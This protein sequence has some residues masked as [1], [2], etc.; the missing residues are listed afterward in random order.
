MKKLIVAAFA[1]AFAA[2]A[3]AATVTWDYTST[4]LRIG[5]QTNTRI[6]DGTLAYLVTTDFTQSAAVEAFANSNGS[7]E[8][9]LSAAS[10]AGALFSGIASSTSGKFNPT[11]VTGTSADVEAYFIVFNGENMFVSSA[12]QAVVNPLDQ[13]SSTIAFTD[14]SAV[15]KAL[16]VNAGEGF[17]SAGWYAAPEPTSG[18]LMLIGMGALALRRRRA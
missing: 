4:Y 15:S 14:G 7:S 5:D 8:A 1:V 11:G 6:A 2:A 13:T 3:Q 10:Q 9:V 12:E 16:P 17:G 18:L